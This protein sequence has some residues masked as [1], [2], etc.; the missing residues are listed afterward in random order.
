MP[1]LRADSKTLIASCVEPCD[2][3]KERSQPDVRCHE[4]LDCGNTHHVGSLSDVSAS[5]L[6]ERLCFL[7]RNLVLGRTGQGNIDRVDERPW[8]GTLV[9]GEFAVGKRCGSHCLALELDGGNGVD[10]L[11]R[12]TLAVVGDEC[13]GRVRQ[14][15]D[16]A[17]ERE[18]LLCSVL[19]DVAGARDKHLLALER[20]LE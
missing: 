11:E 15:E 5:S 6:N 7:L 8:S 10:I 12:E 17:A 9:E 2:T 18:D 1:S 4:V 19:S 16:L 20:L 14:R 3:V 13:T